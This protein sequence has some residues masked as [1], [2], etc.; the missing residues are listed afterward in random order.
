[1]V[2]LPSNPAPVVTLTMWTCS[3]PDGA[4][5]AGLAMLNRT[6][7]V[8]PAKARFFK[9]RLLDQ[10]RPASVASGD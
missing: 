7:A 10:H 6:A 2:A 5:D 9:V 3:G 1:M 4:A 8:R